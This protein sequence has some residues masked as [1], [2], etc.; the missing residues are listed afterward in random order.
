MALYMTMY[1]NDNSHPSEPAAYLRVL[2]AED[3]VVDQK[4][5]SRMFKHMGYQVDVV[6]NGYEMVQAVQIKRYDVLFIDECMPEM[7]ALETAAKVR[8]LPALWKQP[9]IVIMSAGW[10][11]V[12]LS[13]YSSEINDTIIK[14]LSEDELWIALTRVHHTE[15]RSEVK[16]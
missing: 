3:N 16:T 15:N 2:V 1:S 7:N 9:W 11:S 14:P 4:I 10:E 13:A 8:K 5:I 12:V 6:S